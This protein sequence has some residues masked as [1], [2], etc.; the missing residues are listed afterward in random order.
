MSEDFL[1][2]EL[3]EEQ[4]IAEERARREARL[5]AAGLDRPLRDLPTLQPVVTCEPGATVRQ[6]ITIMQERRIGCVLVVKGGHLIGIF[7]E[8]DVLI[9]VAGRD[10]DIDRLTVG[11]VMT[12]D[13]ECLGLDNELV[14]ALNQMSVGGYR[15]VPL[16]DDDE[17][18]VGVVAMRDI[19]NALVA[20]FP[21]D[22]LN[23]PPTP[24]HEISR[25]P[26]GA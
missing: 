11:A 1:D 19:V 5:E 17:V 20:L 4:R 7:T 3:D 22:I 16:L 14:Y 2:E 26:E 13:P 23:L 9:K 6:A 24:G 18:P 12:P 10:V 8:R 25:T 15:H 21:E